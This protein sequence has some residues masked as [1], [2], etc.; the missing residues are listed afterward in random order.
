M[1]VLYRIC[2]KTYSPQDPSGAARSS[3]GRW[4]I[5]GQRVLYLSS[6]LALCILE[7]RANGVTFPSIR[8]RYHFSAVDIDPV[9][10]GE[11]PP[12]SFYAE[13]WAASK[14]TSQR[15]GSGW[16]QERNSLLLGV[17]SAVLTTERN[18]LV[19]AL[20][21]A[22]ERMKFSEPLEIPLDPRLG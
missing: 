20:H 13:R 3:E 17:R 12:A 22:F 19:N 5:I 15:F 21:P 7:M 10:Y 8:E 18:Y 9:R 11:E 1:A 14:E 16:Y 4:H 6:S 2:A